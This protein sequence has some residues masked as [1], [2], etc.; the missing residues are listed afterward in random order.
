M[1]PCRVKVLTWL[2]IMLN[3]Q[4][5]RL[6]FLY[7]GQNHD[8]EVLTYQHESCYRMWSATIR[9]ETVVLLDLLSYQGQQTHHFPC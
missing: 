2:K 4:V 5:T 1:S 9:G 6:P 3:V 8:V 7:T